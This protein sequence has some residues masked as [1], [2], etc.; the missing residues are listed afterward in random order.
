MV[1]LDIFTPAGLGHVL[2]ENAPHG[3]ER[4]GSPKFRQVSESWKG[5]VAFCGVRTERPYPPSSMK[6]N[7]NFSFSSSRF[8]PDICPV[9]PLLP[10]R[11]RWEN[12]TPSGTPI[13]ALNSRLTSPGPEMV[14]YIAPDRVRGLTTRRAKLPETAGQQAVPSV[15]LLQKAPPGLAG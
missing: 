8:A 3:S 12:G 15:I 6:A 1:A 14:E 7:S 10:V 5:E 9:H 4:N 2:P 13:A 11:S